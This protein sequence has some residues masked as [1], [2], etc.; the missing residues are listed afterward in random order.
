MN[1]FYVPGYQEFHGL[2]ISDALAKVKNVAGAYYED[3]ADPVTFSQD[4]EFLIEQRW[5]ELNN[6]NRK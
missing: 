4:L 5:V 3:W 6:L 1:I 2:K